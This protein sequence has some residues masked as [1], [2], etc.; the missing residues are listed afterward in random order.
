MPSLF[1]QITQTALSHSARLVVV[2]K[3]QSIEAIQNI[4]D[5]GANILAFNR[6]QEAEEKFAQLKFTEEK[7]LIGHLQKNKA[8]KAVALFDM[9]Q[10]VDSFE[11]AKKIDAE[12]EK[13]E[14]IMPVLLQVNTAEDEQK[15]GFSEEEIK[16]I[17]PEI[18]KLKHIDVHGLMTIG[19]FGVSEEETQQTFQKLKNLFEHFRS[20]ETFGEF[21]QELSM[22]MSDDYS[23][24]LQEGAT[25]IRVGR[26][27]FDAGNR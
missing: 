17:A 19:E 12:A 1:Q 4:I 21:F 5:Q 8:K 16:K 27:V 24:A 18:V 11:L 25:M 23:L 26:K 2:A 6:V 7:H 3:N 10:S 14:K 9:I 20:L 22:G 15:F 13:M